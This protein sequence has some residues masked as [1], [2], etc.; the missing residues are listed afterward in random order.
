MACFSRGSVLRCGSSGAFGRGVRAF[1]RAISVDASPSGEFADTP[2]W[3]GPFETRNRGFWSWNGSIRWS[4]RADRAFMRRPEI[5][6]RGQAANQDE[7]G[8]AALGANAGW[9]GVAPGGGD[10]LGR[11]HGQRVFPV[12]QQHPAHP[13]GQLA[14][15]WVPEAVVSDLVEPLG[16]NVL[17]EAAQEF[18]TGQGAG[19]PLASTAITLLYWKVTVCSSRAVIRRLVMAVRKTYCAR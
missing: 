10:G 12:E 15:R 7:I 16:Q 11:F 14:L 2:R 18:R 9:S 3:R 17:A 19:A 1:W 8:L 13:A 6:G 5:T 4:W